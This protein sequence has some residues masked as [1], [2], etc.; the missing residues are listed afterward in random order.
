MKFLVT[1]CAQKE[2][3]LGAFINVPSQER[4]PKTTQ[5]YEGETTVIQRERRLGQFGQSLSGSY[6]FST[7]S[8]KYGGMWLCDGSH[9]ISKEHRPL[10]MKVA[11]QLV[12]AESELT[13]NDYWHAFCQSPE[14]Q[15]YDQYVRCKAFSTNQLL[16]F[17]NEVYVAY[18]KQRL[19]VVALRRKKMNVPVNTS[20]SSSV[21]NLS[22]CNIHEFI[23][24]STSQDG[25]QYNVNMNIGI[26]DCK[27]GQ[28]GKVCKHQVASSEA[29]LMEL[30]Q[31]FISTQKTRQRIAD[32][33]LGK[34][35]MLP[36]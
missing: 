33:V 10:L 15:E 4:M 20:S 34:D 3:T 30:P 17:M 6:V 2:R 13:P 29:Y 7:F 26:C 16:P 31:V 28:T 35:K 8:S 23:V 5:G 11:R 1:T 12:Y 36:S 25:V 22:R 27:T 21:S 9:K 19:L 24:N 18:M 14:A 32:I